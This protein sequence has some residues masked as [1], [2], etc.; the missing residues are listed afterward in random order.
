MA[1]F[2]RDY[3]EIKRENI[4]MSVVGTRREGIEQEE[5]VKYIRKRNAR[6][7][8]APIL[9]GLMIV[10]MWALAASPIVLEILFSYNH[11]PDS[12]SI[13]C[14]VFFSLMAIFSA[15]VIFVKGGL[16]RG[17]LFD[18]DSPEAQQAIAGE[19]LDRKLKKKYELCQ[20]HDM[21][22]MDSALAGHPVFIGSFQRPPSDVQRINESAFVTKYAKQ[23][24]QAQ[25]DALSAALAG[26]ARQTAAPQVVDLRSDAERA[27]ESSAGNALSPEREQLARDMVDFLKTHDTGNNMDHYREFR[28]KFHERS[29]AIAEGGGYHQALQEIFYRIRQLCGEQG[30]YFH[31]GAVENVFNGGY[32]RS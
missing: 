31:S 10:I 24:A 18:P 2:E 21:I 28:E 25:M 9:N 26:A 12:F 32:W 5:V 23:Y 15:V 11:R 16:I 14:A 6:V 20:I 1:F 22:S 17:E 3:I 27:I 7:R 19:A 29:E 8:R 4:S 30:V 13:G